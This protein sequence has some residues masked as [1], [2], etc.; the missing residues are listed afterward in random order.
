ME[1]AGVVS[2]ETGKVRMEAVPEVQE[3]VD[4]IETYCADMERR[5]GY[6]TP[7]GRLSD[8]EDNVSVLLPFGVFAVIAPFNFP[9]A[10][11]VNMCAAALV[12]GN[13]V[14][15][16]PSEETPRSTALLGELAIE[17]GLPPGVLNVVHGDDEAGRALVAERRRRRRLHR[18]GRGRPRDR[19]HAATR[20]RR[21]ARCWPRWAAR[22]R[23][24]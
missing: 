7:L 15:L 8:N 10:L 24:S 6:R 11:A 14:V 17:A 9:F 23:R 19:G 18:L 4:L 3:G 22:T 13:T 12:T 2:A 1:I 16:K 20:R 5:D 21:C